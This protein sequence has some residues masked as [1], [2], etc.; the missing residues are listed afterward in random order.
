MS[1]HARRKIRR[2]QVEVDRVDRAVIIE[3]AIPPNLRRATEIGGQKV[4]VD[5]VNGAIKIGV[6]GKRVADEHRCAVHFDA[7]KRRRE[8]AEHVGRFLITKR[9]SVCPASAC[10]G[11]AAGYGVAGPGSAG[12]SAGDE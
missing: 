4:K 8:A 1:R 12:I 3:I 10:R 7:R 6:A 2:Q 11:G 9:G 5:G